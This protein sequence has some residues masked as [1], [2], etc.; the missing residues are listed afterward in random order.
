MSGEPN[1]CAS[2]MSGSCS[3]EHHIAHDESEYRRRFE[4]GSSA[5]HAI[6]PTLVTSQFA[7]AV[8]AMRNESTEV[9]DLIF[10]GQPRVCSFEVITEDGQVAMRGSASLASRCRERGLSFVCRYSSRSCAKAASRVTRS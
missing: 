10:A 3:H 6:G 2:I 9:H 4:E 5:Q 8:R 7:T 1:Q